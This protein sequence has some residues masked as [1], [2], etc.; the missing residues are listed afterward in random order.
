MIATFAGF[1]GFALGTIVTGYLFLGIERRMLEV[2][3]EDRRAEEAKEE[4]ARIKQRMELA[5]EQKRAAS[6]RKRP[7][8]KR[9]A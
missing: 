6:T 7:A 9:R 2:A 5:K 3:Q 1:V 4:A 8:A